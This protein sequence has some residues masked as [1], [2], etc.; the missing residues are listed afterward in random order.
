MSSLTE[1]EKRYFEELFGMRSGYV[2]DFTDRTFSEFFRSTI[3]LNIDDPKYGATS[4]AKR[5]RSFW[6]QASDA[7]VGRILGE[8]LKVCVHGQTD[9]ASALKNDTYV[10]AKNIVARLTEA[11]MSKEISE[12]TRRAIFDFFISTG[13]NWAGRLVED[14]F[15]ARLYDLTDMPSND[16]R[17]RNAAADIHQ[18]RIFNWNDWPDDWIFYDSRFN[19]LHGSDDQLLRFLCETVHP[20]VR[21][22]TNRAR[23]LV[24]AYNRELA[25]DG[26]KIA[27]AKQISGKPIF[28]A[29]T[30]GP[31]GARV[32]VFAEPTGW[33]KVDRQLQEVRVRLD[34]ANTEE[35]YQA[36]GLLCREVL[37]SIAQEVYNPSSHPSPD[38]VAPSDT[39][40]KRMLEAIFNAELQGA[41]NEEARTHAKAAL[42]FA[43]A[44]QHKRTAD[45][46]MAA[47]CAEATSSV[48]NMLAV[49]G[50]R[51]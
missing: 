8:L 49:L 21:P 10:E 32:Q 17:M 24:D 27:E 33:R 9:K 35:Q 29:Q 7:P 47:L 15:L 1:I 13:T 42:R 38:G 20:V 39:D 44:L 48:V 18:H 46:R 22:D 50:G 41:A 43:L 26:W 36:V 11:A 4:K 30:L 5:L 51:R 16:R 31:L 6:E 25:A 28:A 34:T 2:L 3:Q 37:I 45:F 23:E 40:A 19:L 12:V 14:E